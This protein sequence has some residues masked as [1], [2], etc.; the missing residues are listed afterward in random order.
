[1]TGQGRRDILD[2]QDFPM[3]FV[4]RSIFQGTGTDMDELG[5]K[6][7]VAVVNSHTEINAGHMHLAQLAVRAKEG[8]HAAGGIPFEFNVPAPCD[9]IAMGH[10]GMRYVLAQRDLIADIVE[11]HVRSMRFDALVMICSCDKIVPGMLM[12][13][14]RLDLPTIFLTGGHNAFQIRFEPAMKGSISHHDYEDPHDKFAAATCAS[15]GSCEIMG[16]ANT[17]QCL[18]EVMGMSLPGSAAIP[19]FHSDKLRVARRT[20]ARAV[21]LAREGIGAR[22]IL[23][24]Q[25]IDNAIMADLALGGSTNATLHLPAIA[26]EIGVSLPLERFN[27][28]GARI[29][30][31]CGIAPNGPHGMLDLY[32]AGGVPAVLKRI[33]D[34]L[35]LDAPNVAGTTLGD[36]VRLAM[37]RS[38]TVVPPRDSAHSREGGTVILRGNLAPD[39]AVVKQSAVA[40]DMRS[41][42]GPAR[43]FESEA[44]CLA[45]LREGTIKD[46]EVLVL[47]NEGPKGGPG[48]PEMLAATLALELHG[49]KK[50]ALVTDGRFSGATAGPCVGHVSPE[51]YEGGPIALV[52]DGDLIVIDIPGRSI[53]LAVDDGELTR[54]RAEWVRVE[55]EIPPGYMRRYRK[56]VGSAARGA[57][58]GE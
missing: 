22:R 35:H 20:G 32:M 49:L 26:H 37:V 28:L 54:R 23:T 17:F 11:T 18:T 25:A 3:S 58:L 15:C 33:A 29:P 41:T 39:G 19:A 14:A 43:V 10:H 57:V 55:R 21:A 36:V 12:A 8:V 48:M 40:A 1:M 44:D 51:A 56:L 53:R 45:A 4:R 6:P 47:R 46:G 16:T 50:T 9:G 24:A 38:E 27:E 31:I 5:D 52:R 2:L 30:T 34:D 13:A 42:S 7:M